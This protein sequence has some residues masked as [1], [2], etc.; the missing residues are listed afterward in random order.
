[1]ITPAEIAAGT[2][3]PGYVPLPPPPPAATKRHTLRPRCDDTIF[4]A[5]GEC[6]DRDAGPRKVESIESLPPNLK[7]VPGLEARDLVFIRDGSAAVVSTPSGL[8]GPVIYEF[9][10]AHK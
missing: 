1:M 3:R 5:R 7:T 2:P 8:S 4:R 9:R 10:V 6:I